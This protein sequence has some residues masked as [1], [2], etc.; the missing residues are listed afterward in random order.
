MLPLSELK[1]QSRAKVD[2]KCVHLWFILLVSL[3]LLGVHRRATVGDHSSQ[4]LL[5]QCDVDSGEWNA[6][7]PDTGS[8]Q[9]SEESWSGSIAHMV[10]EASEMSTCS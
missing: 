3:H 1:E 6:G 4:Q 8:E 7:H 2:Y 5:Q 10:S 9:R